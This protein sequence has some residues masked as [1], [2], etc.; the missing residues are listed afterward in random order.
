MMT[1]NT[2]HV[3]SNNPAPSVL[4]DLKNS[5][6]MLFWIIKKLDVVFATSFILWVMDLN[7]TIGFPGENL[8]KMRLSTSTGKI[9][10]LLSHLPHSNLLPLILTSSFF[11][12]HPSI[13]SILS[14][15][16]LLSLTTYPNLH[17]FPV[18]NSF[19]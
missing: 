5:L 18:P 16:I 4:M 11:F 3:H 8:R 6:L 13:I 15:I 1:P 14:D 2:L 12:S 9:T 7:T 10:P 19:L 17:N